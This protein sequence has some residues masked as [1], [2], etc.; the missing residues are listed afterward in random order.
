[1]ASGSV[2]EKARNIETVEAIE[3]VERALSLETLRASEG[4]FRILFEAIDQG[5]T[6]SEII[7]ND[8]GEG[9]DYRILEANASFE[10]LT[11]KSRQE[12]LSGKTV[13]ELIP[14][15]EDSWFRRIGRVAVTGESARSVSYLAA[16]D[17]W[18]DVYSFRI[19]DPSQRRVACLFSD[20]TA[21]QRAEQA[22]RDSERVQSYLLKLSDVLR[23]IAD[24]IEIMS[25]GP[26][27]LAR[28]LG[29]SAAGYVEMSED[30]Q[31]VVIGGQYADG[32][33]PELIGPCRLSE[34]GDGFG[35]ALAAGADIFSSD[36]YE[37]ARGPAGGTEKTRDFKIRAAAGT[38]LIKDGRLVALFYAVHFETRQWL[39]WER[40][41]FQ[42]TA[43]RTWAAVERVR[44]ETARRKSEEK[45]HTLFNSI[46]QGFAVLE[47]LY[48]ESGEATN[49]RFIETNPAFEQLTGLKNHLGKT[50]NELIPNLPDSC[51]KAYAHAAETGEPVR[52]DSYSPDFDLWLSVFARRLGNE[53]SRLLNVVFEDVTARKKTE[54]E[55]REGE[56][57]KA[58]LLKLSDAL[59]PLSD[60][61]EIHGTASRL[62]GEHLCADRAH[63]GEVDEEQGYMLVERDYV[64][65]GVPS[66]AGRYPL[67]DFAWVGPAARMD[68]LAVVNDIQTT[69]LIP[70]A[71]RAPM[72][73]LGVGSFIAVSPIKNDRLVGALIV[74]NVKPRT[75][76]AEEVALVQETADR[77]WAAVE[78][79]R[80]EGARRKSEEK[81]RTLFNSID[82]GY[83]VM[84]LLYDKSGAPSD[85]LFIETNRVFENQTGFAN[86][87][88]KTARE[89][90]PNLETFWIRMYARVIETGESVRFE[91][92]VKEIARWFNVFASR[93]GGKDSHLVNVVF[94]DVTARKQSEATLRESEERQAFLL[95]LSD[96][97][98]PLSD[99]IEVQATASRLLGEQLCTDRTH[100]SEVDDEFR[101][102]LIARDYVRDDAPSLAGRY[103]LSDFAW[104]GEEFRS[105]KPTVVD[106]IQTTPLIEE[107]DRTGVVESGVASFICVPL[108]KGDQPFAAL[109]VTNAKPRVW[110]TGEVRLVQETADRTWAAVERARAEAALRE[111]EERFRLFLENV[112]EYALVQVDS[113]LRMTSWNPGAER[114][115]GY[116]SQEALGKTF[117]MLLSPDDQADRIPCMEISS[118]EQMGRSEDA[119]WLVRKDGTRIWTRWVSEPIHD[120]DGHI[121]GLTKVL[122]DET[123][124][125]KTETSLRQSE[126]LAV[127]GR[128]ASSIAHEINNPLEAVTNLIFLARRGEVS[129]EVAQ[130]L[131]LAEH[132]LARVS[133]VTRATLHFHRQA[134]E[135]V[136]ADL[137]TILE[138][139]L[140]LHEG[141]LKASQITTQRL[142]RE[143]PSIKCQENEIRQV[144]ANLVGNAI[145]AM[146]KNQGLRRLTVRV[147]RAV[148]SKTGERGVQVMVADTGSG[149]LESA[150]SHIFEPFFTTKAETG[151]GLGLWISAETVKKHQGTLRFRSRTAGAHRGTVFLLHLGSNGS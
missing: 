17:R 94:D 82:Q 27:L 92:Y 148:D 32:S 20:V 118:L 78:R 84:E 56:E 111:S 48:D 135:P 108:R 149:I 21:R 25:K 123:E 74:S 93:L 75:W 109:C 126:K 116:S 140:Q 122:R 65:E 120:K 30:G 47:V 68:G 41:I 28:E 51:L 54:A 79:V 45:Y 70:D 141:R 77:I 115:F 67:A 4:K 16:L 5:L 151:T 23:P 97:L 52:F 119:R 19:G 113:E 9:I 58:F 85:L 31:T 12:F 117:S 36:I 33:M 134:S 88:G 22:L 95:K 1:M 142:Y 63:Y 61:I 24:P 98:R 147:R 99:P 76:A 18:L 80:A 86:Y 50:T 114:I 38:P 132:E 89:L 110:T 42:Q 104:I 146:A 43:E 40:E 10:R 107:A 101:Y 131:A 73:A 138:S 46:D 137:V 62:L 72:I 66:S 144:L 106:D 55:L 136:E 145:D 90:N 8:A 124:R 81:Y 60:P 103:P 37:D 2:E 87:A 29:V 121:K 53:G 105:G 100:Y 139:V 3:T 91:R 57:R 11:G 128:M 35:P 83:A 44:A 39:T 59:R 112:H 127:V 143:H 15:L 125:L 49:L 26:E 69:P 34:F 14:K 130:L 102:L 6:I 150:M 129:Q 64:R 13:R 96:A 7:L 71:Q 133:H